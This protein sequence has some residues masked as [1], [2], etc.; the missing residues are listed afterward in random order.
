VR[1]RVLRLAVLAAG[2]SAAVLTASIAAGPQTLA[3]TA[4]P[5]TAI[6][7]AAPATALADAAGISA[8]DPASAAPATVVGSPFRQVFLIDGERVL[9][10]HGTGGIG[11][12]QPS[13]ASGL[14][15]PLISLIIGGSTYEIPAVAMP[16]L[17]R[18][19]SP[20]LFDLSAL[21]S[22]ER[23]VR[24]PVRV[25]YR[26]RRPALPG[27][28]ITSS[29]A[30][31]A[32]GY[33]TAS[34]AKV[35]GAAL[36]RQYR[37]D[38]SRGSYG[39]DGV[40][41]DGASI[42]LAGLRAP[43]PARPDYPMHTLT[44]TGSNQAGKPDTGDPVFVF[45]VDNT[46]RI[47]IFQ[48]QNRFYHGVAKYSVPSGHYCAVGIFG[49]GI[50]IFG[51][52]TPPD[53]PAAARIVV[54][55][56]FTVAGNRTV[57]IAE[58]AAS[59][60]QTMSTPRPARV[61]SSD[62]FLV[63]SGRSGPAVGVGLLGF[64]SPIWV[65]P[66]TRRPT[67]GSLRAYSSQELTSPPGSGVRYGY[68]LSYEDPRGAI[69]AQRY[70][71]R[72]ADL[73]TVSSRYYQDAKSAGSSWIF[74]LQSTTVAAIVQPETAYPLSLP[75][76]Q[77]LYLGGNRPSMAWAAYYDALSPA[78]G[79]EGGQQQAGFSFYPAGSHVTDKWNAYPLHPGANFTAVNVPE[80]E[81]VASAARSGNTLTL[82]TTPFSD[83]E[84]GH[85]G[86]GFAALPGATIAGSYQV[87]QDGK[88][89]A[90]GNAVSLASDGPFFAQLKLSTKPSVIT[91][92]LDAS[93]TGKAFRLS[94]AS[95][96]VWTW[97]SAHVPAGARLPPGW[98]CSID[99]ATGTPTF[100]CAVQP[101]MTLRYSVA[102]LALDGSAPPG[103]QVLDVSVGHLQLAKAIRIA[104]ARVRV[105]FND[106]KSWR[107]AS[108]TRRGAGTF[109]AEFTAPAGA[110]VTLRTSA[111]DAA[112]G[113]IT[114]TIR[115]GYQIAS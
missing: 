80:N 45:S 72:P 104:G 14:A 57:H 91:F 85:L 64:G 62:F 69:P 49:T 23:A 46:N 115:H 35:F 42:A 114:E 97:R 38:H 43:S 98:A 41:A 105:S 59:S 111:R 4:V 33:L 113:S 65:S 39:T 8:P 60:E 16:Y 34:S 31:T 44:V 12:S 70:L 79:T 21:M 74:G 67:V 25:S 86:T 30:G 94:T 77:I 63:R 73:V 112:G 100:H 54:L 5:A 93:R 13:P 18:G 89:I 84:P 109:R 90:G 108:V 40:F 47:D 58:R 82:E 106:G 92:K 27:V 101:M 71:V 29:G 6:S 51:N 37:A 7:A 9:A 95:R 48:A 15:G 3:T 55:P 96:T 26:M 22:K 76:G 103:R 24:L 32:D 52:S 68:A 88:K 20:D 36:D 61:S 83:N 81:T 78:G 19:L 110:Y 2:M 28:T 75:G 50:T 66:T 87:D 1:L 107:D 11:A 102:G 17:G 10:S 53:P 56:Q 99:Q